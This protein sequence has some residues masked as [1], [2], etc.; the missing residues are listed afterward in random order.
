MLPDLGCYLLQR[1][2]EQWHGL[3]RH[4]YPLQHSPINGCLSLWRSRF[5]ALEGFHELRV[6]SYQYSLKAY[7]IRHEIY[8]YKEAT[9]QKI[10]NSIT[11]W[12]FLRENHHYKWYLGGNMSGIA[13]LAVKYAAIATSFKVLL[14]LWK[15]Y[16]GF[17]VLILACTTSVG[18]SWIFIYSQKRMLIPISLLSFT[19]SAPQ[20][21]PRNKRKWRHTK[22]NQ[23]AGM[24]SYHWF[25]LQYHL[26]WVSSRYSRVRK[27]G[28]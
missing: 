19:I 21:K 20:K 27:M 24:H 2:S 25:C 9:A 14:H 7:R 12:G 5:S 10:P 23:F 13:M 6:P 28:F 15:L 22:A 18:F 1:A 17:L 11:I 8:P 26:H 16:R 3:Y 4:L